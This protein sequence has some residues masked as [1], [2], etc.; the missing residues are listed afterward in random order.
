MTESHVSTLPAWKDRSGEPIPKAWCRHLSEELVKRPAV[1]GCL[2][3]T[4]SS[5]LHRQLLHHLVDSVK[6]CKVRQVL[7]LILGRLES[8]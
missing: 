7:E 6:S 2:H 3:Q 8:W 5:V 1:L 4:Q